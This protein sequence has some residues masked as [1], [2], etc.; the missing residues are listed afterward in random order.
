MGE[1]R[2]FPQSR[3]RAGVSSGEVTP[4]VGIYH[5][6]WGAARHDR[7]SGVHRP[8]RH[9]TLALAPR[10]GDDSRITLLIGLDHCLFWHREMSD[11]LRTISAGSGVPAER[12]TVFF[13]HTHAAGLMGYEREDLPGGEWIR[14]YLRQ[15]G[16]TLSGAV[17]DAVSRLTP[18][19]IGY[20]SGSCRLARNRDL[21]APDSGEYVCGYSPDGMADDTVQV[22]RITD[23]ATGQPLLTIVNYACHPT[24]LAWDNTL[25][26]PDYVG[27]MRDVI[28]Q[29]TGVPTLF[30]QGASGDIGPRDG[31]VGD[32]E[33][34]DRNGRQL[35]YAVLS[36]WESLPPPGTRF[37]YGGAVTSGATIGTWKHVPIDDEEAR[38][39]E[40]WLEE[41]PA[42]DLTYRPDLP[43]R[44][45]LLEERDHW[46]ARQTQ[47][48]AAGDERT[49][50]ECRA[51][52]E[53]CT[54]RLTRIDALPPGEAYPYRYQLR[55]LGDAIWIAL[56]G[57]HYNILQRELRRR[58]PGVPI[59][60]GTLA[61]GSQVWYLPD[62][63]SYGKGLY[64]ENASVLARGSL[65]RLID[66]IADALRGQFGLAAPSALPED[67]PN[68][69][70]RD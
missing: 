64:Q 23:D 55:R 51:I 70:L 65:E 2:G 66:H 36:A 67:S 13:T 48:L 26:S 18:A 57:E 25:I 68:E 9:T 19:T 20:E 41:E 22:G 27:A 52:I 43:Q 30:I 45:P 56:D 29:R 54:R 7:S 63:H 34:A 62:E 47:A 6:M 60:V 32:V 17:R 15:L 8:L 14:G 49:A 21:I 31:F 37:E 42:L 10:D 28:E 16:E 40:R 35:G 59:V 24:T 4:P 3:C 69:D 33:V 39:Q 46:A 53:R 38:R 11:L 50:A 5:R 61:N 58:F 44:E 1:A 12:I